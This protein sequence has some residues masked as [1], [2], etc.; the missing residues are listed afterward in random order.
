MENNGL[1]NGPRYNGFYLLEYTT[2]QFPELGLSYS[3]S[4]PLSFQ[5]SDPSN[6]KLS[7]RFLLIAIKLAFHSLTP[8]SSSNLPIFLSSTFITSFLIFDM[9]AIYLMYVSYRFKFIFFPDDHLLVPA[10]F[11]K[12]PVSFIKKPCL[13]VYVCVID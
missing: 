13:C 1:I 5:L 6:F 11:I 12:S 3:A 4:L 7:Y 2:S 9:V 10:S 8:H